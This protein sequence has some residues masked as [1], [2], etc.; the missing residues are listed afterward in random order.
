MSQAFSNHTL[1]SFCTRVLTGLAVVAATT[2]SQAN[3]FAQDNQANGTTPKDVETLRQEIVAKGLKYL[4]EQ[5]QAED[6]SFTARAGAGITALAVTA[7]LRNG[8]TNDDPMVNKGLKSL[9]GF[10]KP[11]GGIYG[12][13]RLKNYETCVA[14][15]AFA[16]ANKDGKYDKILADAQ[17]FLKGLQIGDDE[18]KQDD[19]WYGGVGYSGSERPD[20]SNTAYFIDALIASGADKDDPNIQ[21]ALIFVG[22]CQNN[23]GK[24]NDTR[25]ADKIDDGGFYYS[26]PTESVD[27]SGDTERFSPNGGIRSYGSMS[28]SGL[29]SMIYAG[30]TEKD[31]RVI[32]A[33]KWI[34]NTYTVDK[35]PGMGNAGLF[36]YYHTFGAALNAA[37]L[38]S[39]TDADGNKHDW[40]ADLVRELA[41]R[42]NENG[43]WTNSNSRWFEN[44]PNLATS[45]ALMALSYCEKE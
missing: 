21:K 31:P 35:H 10:V 30:L 11:D 41:K 12:G 2:I 9:E 32:A 29:K 19:P 40:R 22:R 1:A 33:N 27:P 6:G 26:I 7:A 8:K 25:F 36:Y 24:W 38:E 45:F 42:Q 23:K 34:T 17:K 5:G 37:K 13:G 15:V 14:T 16:E 3:V 28:Y 4:A 18:R 43:S 44:D 20:L 39:V